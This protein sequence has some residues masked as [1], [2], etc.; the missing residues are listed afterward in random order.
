MPGVFRYTPV[1]ALVV[2]AAGCG[3]S[4]S[5]STT[6]SAQ[7]QRVEWANSVCAPLV[8][9][10]SSVKATAS[11]L[12]S[13]QTPANGE[14]TNAATQVDDATKTLVNSLKS[15]GKPPSPAA[16][17]AKNTVD[18][19]QSRLSDAGNQIKSDVS[20]ISGVEDLVTAATSIEATAKTMGS[21]ISS[22]TSKL[23]SLGPNGEWKQ[24]FSDA[25]SCKSLQGSSSK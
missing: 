7:S 25:D 8:A 22:A 6:T 21:A 14:L 16:D 9:W 10:D 3:S 4:G 17:D 2:L 1:L 23:K 12:K 15:V 5:N 11:Q 20:G 13:S 24:A 19:L 18:D